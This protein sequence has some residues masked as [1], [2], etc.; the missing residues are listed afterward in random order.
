[1]VVKRDN[2]MLGKGKKYVIP[3]IQEEAEMLE[4]AGI[5][6]GEEETY[7]LGKSIK[8]LA[9]MSGA[10]ALKFVG[11]MY[12]TQKDYWLASGV[13]IPGEESMVSANCEKRG[14][15][16]NKF[17]YW[18]TDNLLNDWIQL[19]DCRPEHIQGARMIQHV[20]TGDLNADID[21]NP[22]FPGKERHFLRAQLARIF[23]ATSIVPKGLVEYDEETKEVKFAED[24]TI[25]GTEELKSL[26]AWG[27][28]L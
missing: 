1:M 20:L 21:S 25:P 4:W 2:G 22:S 10:G 23:A 17:V 5:S 18:V 24:F 28:L 3:N 6:F 13:L 26:E 19:P 7:K 15:G 14:E 9:V 16:V 11:K 12:G 8:R 27:N